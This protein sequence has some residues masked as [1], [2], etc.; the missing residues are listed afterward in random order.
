MPYGQEVS[1]DNWNLYEKRYPKIENNGRRTKRTSEP[2]YQSRATKSKDD[3][4]ASNQRRL[5]RSYL[6]A[7]P[8]REQTFFIFKK[9]FLNMSREFT[10]RFPILETL[11]KPTLHDPGLFEHV[12]LICNFK[13]GKKKNRPWTNHTLRNISRKKCSWQ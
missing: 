4:R 6:A 5:E 12:A 10:Y 2:S 7:F 11:I 8:P 13:K 3:P 9:R 1:S